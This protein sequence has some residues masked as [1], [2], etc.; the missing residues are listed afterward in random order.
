VD[1]NVRSAYFDARANQALVQVARENLVNLQKHLE[2][3]REM[4]EAGTR[5]RST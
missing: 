1:F 3:T 4:V 2:Q 5:R